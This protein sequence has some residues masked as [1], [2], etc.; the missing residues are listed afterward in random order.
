MTMNRQNQT[1]YRLPILAIAI[2]AV[3]MLIAGSIVDRAEAATHNTSAVKSAVQEVFAEVPEMV[4]VAQCESKFRQ[5]TDSG[6]VFYGGYGGHMV[7]V[8]QVYSL[9]HQNA[10]ATLGY[11][12]TT[13]E[14]NIGYARHLYN[15][16]GLT[17]WNS[18]R[19]CWETVVENSA[20]TTVSTGE[21]VTEKPTRAELA[22]QLEKLQKLVALLT[23][24]L[25]L[26]N[27]S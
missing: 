20:S 6:N 4:A 19:T 24:L 8:F 12:I 3:A 10:A 26:R 22:A 1:P 5:Y 25:E 21:V 11:D 23:T 9:V 16:Q 2:V 7:G 15:T 18:S 17:P 13:L 27:L 14:G